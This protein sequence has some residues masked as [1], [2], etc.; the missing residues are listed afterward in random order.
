LPLAISAKIPCRA[1]LMSVMIKFGIF[2]SADSV[3]VDSHSSARLGFF[4]SIQRYI[5]CGSSEG[6]YVA[7]NGGLTGFA[8][9]S[10]NRIRKLWSVCGQA[11]ITR[12]QR[13]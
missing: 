7:I 10:K 12:L 9:R 2:G 8:A 5:S 3:G 13:K 1:L 11:W 4:G 6:T